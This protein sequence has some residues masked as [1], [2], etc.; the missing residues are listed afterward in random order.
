MSSWRDAPYFTEA[1]RVALALTEAVLQPA[2]HGERVCDELYA[3]AAR[4]YEPG[5]WS[6]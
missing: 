5:R 4:H 3:E 1:E 6:R 2:A